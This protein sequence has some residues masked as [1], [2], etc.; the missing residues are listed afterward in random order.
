MTKFRGSIDDLKQLIAAQG[1][2]GVWKELPNNAFQF[3][4]TEGAVLNFY[5]TKTIQ[6]QGPKAL[7]E[8]L[9]AKLARSIEDWKPEQKPLPPISTNAQQKSGENKRI[10]VV[11]GHDQTAREQ[12]ELILHRLGLDPFVLAN[13]AGGGL[14]LIEALEKEIGPQPGQCRFGIVLLTPDDLGYSKNDGP[15]KAEPRARQNVVLEMGMVLAALRRQNVVILKKGHIEIPSDIQG[16]IYIGFN[17]HVKETVP[18]LVERLNQ[19]GFNL[20]ASAI[21]RATA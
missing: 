6:F 19:A 8:E 3:T 7:K 16:I 18:K 12:L 20:D 13:T 1:I 11:H 5:G 4:S 15:E 9:E 17:A 2:T 10:F 21:A 14:T